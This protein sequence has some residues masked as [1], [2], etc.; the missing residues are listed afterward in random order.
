MRLN[1]KMPRIL[2]PR[3]YG[4]Y[5]IKVRIVANLDSN[6]PSLLLPPKWWMYF[7]THSRAVTMSS[8]PMLPAA[9]SVSR[10]KK[11]EVAVR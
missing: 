3:S 10:H 7:W 6:G 2:K 11:P 1:Q 5:Y 8:I 9:S 4:Y